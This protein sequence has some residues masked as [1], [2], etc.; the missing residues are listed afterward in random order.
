M[1]R[2]HFRCKSIQYF[3]FMRFFLVLFIQFNRIVQDQN[4]DGIAILVVYGI[5]PK[6][7]DL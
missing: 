6:V 5:L 7:P 1:V 4:E 3:V 2:I